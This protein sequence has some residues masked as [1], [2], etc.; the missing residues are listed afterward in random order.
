M[1]AE[2]AA[3]LDRAAE[4]IER[5]GLHKGAMFDRAESAPPEEC[6]VC[7]WGAL[8][9]AVVGTPSLRTNTD[10]R[11]VKPYA[12]VLAAFLGLPGTDSSWSV[13]DWNDAPERTADEVIAALKAAAQAEREAS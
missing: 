13:P 5:N 6:P 2:T 4:I 3:I 8:A 12:N 10:V 7:P 9:I 1:S 11:A